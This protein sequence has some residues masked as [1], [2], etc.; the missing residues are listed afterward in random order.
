MR[1]ILIFLFCFSRIYIFGQVEGDSP[2]TLNDFPPIFLTSGENVYGNTCGSVGY[3]TD[4]SQDLQ[5]VSCDNIPEENAIWYI[6]RNYQGY[7]IDIQITPYTLSNN[8]NIE[9]YGGDINT[10]CNSFPT[11]ITSLCNI[12]PGINIIKNIYANDHKYVYIKIVSTESD[13][14]SFDLK[15]TLKLCA[16]CTNNISSLIKPVTK[17]YYEINPICLMGNL[18]FGCTNDINIVSISDYDFTHNPVAW[19]KVTTD[20]EA[21]NIIV[22]ATTKGKWTPIWQVFESITGCSEMKKL[23]YNKTDCNNKYTNQGYT[24]NDLTSSRTYYIIVS[25]DPSKLP[26][27]HSGFELCVSTLRQCPAIFDTLGCNPIDSSQFQ[28][29]DR[30]YKELEPSGPPYYGPFIPGEELTC[31]ININYQGIENESNWFMAIIP[32]FNDGWNMNDFDIAASYKPDTSIIF[33]DCNWYDEKS[34]NCPPLIA[35]SLPTLCTYRDNNGILRICN[36][37]CEKCPCE[38]GIK[39][40]DTIPSGYY[41]ITKGNNLNCSSEKCSPTFHWGLGTTDFNIKWEFKIKTRNDIDSINDSKREDLQIK[42]QTLNDGIAGCWSDPDN[43]HIDL[44][45]FSPKWKVTSRPDTLFQNIK[46]SLDTISPSNMCNGQVAKFRITSPMNDNVKLIVKPLSN[47]NIIGQNDYIFENGTGLISDELWLTDENICKDTLYYIYG[48]YNDITQSVLHYDT[49][50]FVVY[51]KPNFSLKNK[52]IKQYIFAKKDIV[53]TDKFLG[54]TDNLRFK[55][56][57]SGDTIQTEG[58]II[59]VKGHFG[60]GKHKILVHTS[61]DG[62]CVQDDTFT[63]EIYKNLNHYIDS[64]TTTDT[65]SP[66]DK[67]LLVAKKHQDLIDQKLDR[68]IRLRSQNDIANQDIKVIPNPNSGN[69]ELRFGNETAEDIFLTI[70]SSNGKEIMK[71]KINKG[72]KRSK[73]NLADVKAGIYMIRLSNQISYKN[74]KFVLIP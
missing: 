28:I 39:A 61:L 46:I 69:F 27:D 38:A 71:S 35:R 73:I 12:A 48:V 42:I 44:P 14:G 4:P 45:Y 29:V 19:Y 62:N 5:N 3:D 24:V 65:L 21:K 13:C 51:Q 17:D 37:L 11:Y 15:A 56:N 22:K 66:N 7:A 70:L 68:D 25:A 26:F 34:K 20:L 74:I 18:N 32:Q 16:D 6:I 57:L 30:V 41:F 58:G 23:T 10:G 53:L 60:L 8:M 63:L 52:I 33:S 1:N 49:L 59:K 2:C 9:V 55:W 72:T 36:T 47:A 50:K 43:L 67:S 31:D 64:Y 54:C 40:L